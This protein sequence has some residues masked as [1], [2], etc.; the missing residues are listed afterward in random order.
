M[1]PTEELLDLA[2]QHHDS[3]ELEQAAPL[4]ERV[5]R[6]DPGHPGALYRLGALELQRSNVTVSVELLKR[7]AEKRPDLAEVHNALGV[8]CKAMGQWGAA[9]ES[10]ERALQVN[11]HFS[12]AY[13]NLGDLSQTLGQ[14]DRAIEFYL[15]SIKLYPHDAEPFLRLGDLLFAR[16]I[17][18]GAEQCLRRVLD[19]AGICVTSA[20]G[21]DHG[22]VGGA[23]AHSHQ[24]VAAGQ[25]EL[26]LLSRL[27]IACLKQ[28]KLDDA[29]A[30]FRR[31]LDF[32][33]NLAEMHSNLAYVYERQGKL[34]EAVA[35]GELATRLRP[36]YAEGH[37]NL[38]VAYRALHR[39][40]AAR[41]SFARAVELKPEFP[42]GRFNLAT[43]DL[44]EGDYPAGWKGYE[45]RLA[46]LPQAPRQ[47]AVPRWDGKTI[48]TRAPQEVPTLLVHA[49]QGYG[50]TI[51]F[52]RFL[53]LAKE[54]SDATLV[55]ESPSALVPLLQGFPG[56]DVVVAAGTRG[57]TTSAEVPLPSLPGLLGIRLEDLPG[58]VGYLSVP[59]AYR[60]KW[61]P[62]M[63]EM[64]DSLTQRCAAGGAERKLRVGI[65]WRGNPAQSQNVV[66]S[67]PLAEI[68]RLA[69]VRDV[70]WFSLQHDATPEELGAIWPKDVSIAAL[71][72]DLSDF[73][74]TA[75]VMEQLDLVITVDTSVA[76]LAGA[77]AVPCWTLLCHTPDWRWQLDCPGTPWYPGMK[78]FRQPEWG[79]WRD[80]MDRVTGQLKML[81]AP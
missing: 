33:P 20:C 72:A 78:L 41:S 40:D 56:V 28:E 80:V 49:E 22:P 69:G 39:L 5:L 46:T 38:G 63:K 2:V 4:Y 29:A 31:I 15:Q 55:V 57:P 34:D 47:F 65:A 75:A 11:P 13:F 44:M 42:L 59:P 79:N 62:R 37:N 10:F 43:I 27:G 48:S 50:D 60:E 30:V 1:E 12:E 74:D 76:H 64:I 54:R 68:A 3:G 26:E 17:W 18:P 9:A 21:H 77:L 35:E 81:V 66:R 53:R 14:T 7:A 25:T 61:A 73:G 51:Q 58:E 23:H 6:L 36:N 19:I 45:A 32:D 16:E 67:C 52:A 70:L 71:G 8:A 24:G